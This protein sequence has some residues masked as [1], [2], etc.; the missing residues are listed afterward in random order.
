MKKKATTNKPKPRKI[1]IKIQRFIKNVWEI[2]WRPEMSILPGQLAFFIILSLVPTITIIGYG[3]SFFDISVDTIINALKHNFSPNVVEMIMPI[4]SG[5]SLDLKFVIII[6]VMFYIASNGAA[7]I[8]VASNTIYNVRQS[9]WLKRRIKALFLTFIFVILYL[10]ILLVPAFGMKIINA[11]DYF[12]IKSVVTDIL[13][14]LQSPIS[15]LIIFLFIKVIYTIAPDKS[16]PSSRLNPGALFTTA[17]WVI[18]T[19]IYSFYV[20]NFAM[21]YDLFYAGLANIAVLMLWIYC[22]SLTFVIG[23]SLNYRALEEELEKTGII[24]LKN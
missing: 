6:C 9:S 11:I 5:E 22:L 14:I 16:L 2:F 23:L 8:I 12:N 4:L 1:Q 7:S 13:G 20:N 18:T 10:F 24:N 21:Q 17:C 3:A 15:W 19:Y